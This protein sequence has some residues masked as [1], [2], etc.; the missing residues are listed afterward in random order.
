MSPPSEQYQ[1]R[2][3]RDA[4][5]E[6]TE[7][8]TAIANSLPAILDCVSLRQDI[9]DAQIMRALYARSQGR[10]SQSEIKKS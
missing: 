6:A 2:T 10:Q 7:N 3:P 1:S 5:C 8:D 9:R 4:L